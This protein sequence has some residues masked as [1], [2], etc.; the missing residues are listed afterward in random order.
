MQ[1]QLVEIWKRWKRINES[2]FE[3][4][5]IELIIIV[6]I[7]FHRSSHTVQSFANEFYVQK[8]SSCSIFVLI[9]LSCI[10]HV[11]VVPVHNKFQHIFDLIKLKLILFNVSFEE[12][13]IS[14]NFELLFDFY[15][16]LSFDADS[17]VHHRISNEWLYSGYCWKYDA[18]VFVMAGSSTQVRKSKFLIHIII[19]KFFLLRL[20][21]IF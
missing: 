17:T 12:S 14:L 21:S 8:F 6:L 13:D 15:L 4:E 10:Y 1:A 3:K 7:N 20:L 5:R 18:R 19:F 16:R 9:Y 11:L 2:V